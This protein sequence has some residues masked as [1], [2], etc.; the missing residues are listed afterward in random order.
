MEEVLLSSE[1]IDNH[2]TRLAFEI[3]SNHSNT[4]RPIVLLGVMN[5]S[6]PFL[7]DLMMA[8]TEISIQ[9]ET[10]KFQTY[11]DT[12]QDINKIPKDILNLELSGRVVIIVDDMIDSG[13]TITA[14]KVFLIKRYKYVNIET[15]CM[16][17]RE[18]NNIDVDYVGCEVKKGIWVKGYGMDNAEGLKRN[19]K[20]ILIDKYI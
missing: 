15:C 16:L 17:K 1:E 2:V 8:I 14:L 6:I 13:N 3:S 12:I 19:Q 18:N 9:V 11:T 4:K 20:R 5:G 7:N 10:I